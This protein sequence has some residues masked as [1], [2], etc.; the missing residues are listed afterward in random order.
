MTRNP[1]SS[2]GSAPAIGELLTGTSGS[3][4]RTPRRGD[5]VAG[6]VADPTS[7]PEMRLHNDAAR[8]AAAL[9]N[10][11]VSDG[12]GPVPGLRGTGDRSSSPAGIRCADPSSLAG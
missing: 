11:G 9:H 5:R 1:G 2:D 10:S 8:A 12:D 6:L 4:P 3:R 7:S